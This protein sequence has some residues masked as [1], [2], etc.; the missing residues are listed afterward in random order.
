MNVTRIQQI[1][2]CPDC[3]SELVFA[4]ADSLDSKCPQCPFSATRLNYR[5]QNHAAVCH[6]SLPVAYP[7]ETALADLDLGCGNGDY[8][9]ACESLGYEWIGV[10]TCEN[11]PTVRGD[12]HRLPFHD[13]S[14]DVVFS[15]AVIEHVHNPFLAVAEVSRV[16]APGGRFIGASAFGEPFHTSF[17]HASHWGLVSLFKSQGLVIERL[18]ACRSTLTAL[19]DMGGYPRVV[20]WL[21]GMIARLARYPVLSPR[22]WLYSNDSL[23]EAALTTAGSIGFLA[24]KV[25]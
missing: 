17:F 5:P 15:V 14:F 7:F 11:G 4:H 2:R 20:R 12:L 1:L 13:A 19:S 23:A 9:R 24:H 18:W 10:D 25:A 22:R 16:L 6:L 21:I 3:Q 8:R